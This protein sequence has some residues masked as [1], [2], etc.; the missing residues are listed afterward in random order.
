MLYWRFPY[1]GPMHSAVLRYAFFC[2]NRAMVVVVYPSSFPSL[3]PVELAIDRALDPAQ[4]FVSF[5]FSGLVHVA[6]L[7]ATLVMP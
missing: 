5:L 2:G 7:Y 6:M 4:L 3:F 1:L